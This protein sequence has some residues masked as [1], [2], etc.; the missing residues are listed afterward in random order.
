MKRVTLL[1]CLA[2]AYASLDAFAG[3]FNSIYSPSTFT[4]A[5]TLNLNPTRNGQTVNEGTINL[6]SSA[7]NSLVI[8]GELINRGELNIKQDSNINGVIENHGQ[9]QVDAGNTL[10]LRGSLFQEAG[11]TTVEGEF[12]IVYLD[13]PEVFRD[14]LQHF[15]VDDQFLERRR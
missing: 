3:S 2:V 1:I 6:R 11:Q 5:G 7:R 9:L 8:A 4:S 10:S 14:H 15:C 12:I 13:R